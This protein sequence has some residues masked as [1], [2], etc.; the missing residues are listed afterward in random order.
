MGYFIAFFIVLRVVPHSFVH[1]V[2]SP[3][4]FYA[5]SHYNPPVFS[6]FNLRDDFQ[7]HSKSCNCVELYPPTR[8]PGFGLVYLFCFLYALFFLVVVAVVQLFPRARSVGT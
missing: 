6:P 8:L 2:A 3:F 7:S 1:F 5:L 4:V